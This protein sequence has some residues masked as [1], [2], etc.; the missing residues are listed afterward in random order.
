VPCKS[1]SFFRP[2]GTGVSWQLTQGLRPG[3]NSSALGL[4]LCWIES[5]A[6]PQAEALAGI[7]APRSRILHIRD[8][9]YVRSFAPVGAQDDKSNNNNVES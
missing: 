2:S 5:R 7:G 1:G 9:W 8:E 4:R 3:L 6:R